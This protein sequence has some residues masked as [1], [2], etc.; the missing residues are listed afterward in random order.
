VNWYTIGGKQLTKGAQVYDLNLSSTDCEYDN[1]DADTAKC[2]THNTKLGDAAGEFTYG[3]QNDRS[4]NSK[5]KYFYTYDGEVTNLIAH[6][7]ANS[8]YT[9]AKTEK[10][11]EAKSY[12][13]NVKMYTIH[14]KLIETCTNTVAYEDVCKDTELKVTQ[15]SKDKEY[16]LWTDTEVWDVPTQFSTTKYPFCLP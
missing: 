7:K 9:Y 11:S 2:K 14:D 12:T 16:T 8:K 5:C 1:Y 13:T 3:F 10:I 15:Y 4:V 6:D